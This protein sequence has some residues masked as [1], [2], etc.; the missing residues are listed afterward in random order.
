MTGMT[1]YLLSVVI[2]HALKS[3]RSISQ[4]TTKPATKPQ[5]AEPILKRLTSATVTS[6]LTSA[7]KV[8]LPEPNEVTK[9]L[10][11]ARSMARPPNTIMNALGVAKV[12]LVKVGASTPK[13][14]ARQPK[15]SAPV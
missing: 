5:N 10:C 2:T 4:D 15:A 12:R 8:N 3:C 7:P 11:N 13:S 9:A 1:L 14:K 6:R